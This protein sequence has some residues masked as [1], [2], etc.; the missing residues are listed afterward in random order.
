MADMA[1][2]NEDTVGINAPLFTAT[3]QQ[4]PDRQ[5]ERSYHQRE[6]F[7]WMKTY[8]TDIFVKKC[9]QLEYIL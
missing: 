3:Y 4:G 1:P 7:Q 5:T 6:M 8:S 9:Y 2:A